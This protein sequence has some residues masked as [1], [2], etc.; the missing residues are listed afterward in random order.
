M[1]VSHG[2]FAFWGA[3]ACGI[4]S[5][6]YIAL[7][8][9]RRLV[10][11]NSSGWVWAFILLNGGLIG[12]AGSLLVAGMAQAFFERAIGGSTLEAFIA[13]QENPWFVISMYSFSASA[14]YSRPDI[15]RSLELH[16]GRRRRR[17]RSAS[18]AG[19]R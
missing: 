13:G 11:V 4:L 3:Y 6:C 15:W 7:Q 18:A 17:C 10:S 19:S 8:E 1:D 14:S 9:R 2:H 12:M 16:T 5:V